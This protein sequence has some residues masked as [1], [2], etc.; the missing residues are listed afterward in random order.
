MKALTERLSGKYDRDSIAV[1][2][3]SIYRLPLIQQLGEAGL[4]VEH[5]VYTL[6]GDLT[7]NSRRILNVE[8]KEPFLSDLLISCCPDH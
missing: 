3:A 8:S 5:T 6:T 7:S 1:P 2:A 4:F